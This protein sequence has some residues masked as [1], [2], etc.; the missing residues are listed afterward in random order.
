MRLLLLLKYPHCV[1]LLP[2]HICALFMNMCKICECFTRIIY[3]FNEEVRSTVHSSLIETML[4][5]SNGLI[6]CMYEYMHWR[7]RVCYNIHRTSHI[8][9]SLCARR[10]WCWQFPLNGFVYQSKLNE[11]GWCGKRGDSRYDWATDSTSI[12]SRNIREC[13]RKT[14]TRGRPGTRLSRPKQ[15]LSNENQNIQ[16]TVMHDTP[17]MDSVCGAAVEF[18]RL[19]RIIIYFLYYFYNK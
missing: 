3:F 19:H 18:D 7:V 12:G 2:P 15:E 17:T 11:I 10:W 6:M 14:H 9:W 8:H 16:H 13:I 4:F 5:G 1:L